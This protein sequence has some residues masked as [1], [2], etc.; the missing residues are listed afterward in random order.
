MGKTAGNIFFSASFTVA[1]F[2]SFCWLISLRAPLFAAFINLKIGAL[3]RSS[4]LH[5]SNIFPFSLFEFILTLSPAIFLLLIYFIKKSKPAKLRTNFFSILG[6]FLILFSVFVFTVVIGYNEN[7]N[8]ENYDVSDEKTVLAAEYLA[9]R[10][11]SFAPHAFPEK[12]QLSHKLYKA[13]R[14]LFPQSSNPQ[15]RIK[16][17]KNAHLASRLGI[18]AQFSFPTS[19]INVNFKAPEYISTFSAAH[20][21][22][23]LFGISDEAQASLYAYR[24]S[25]LTEDRGIMYSAYLSAFEYVFSDVAKID[26]DLSAEIYESLSARAKSDIR[27]Y[28]DFYNDSKGALTGASDSANEVLLETIDKNGSHSYSAFSKLIVLYLSE[29]GFL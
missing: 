3:L 10:I 29:N 5:F 24:A 8:E 17:I 13:Y 25:M 26:P 6:V 20:E 21:F 7:T 1:L 28:R 12:E 9:E 16:A 15:P 19:E 27:S 14:S 23:H 4:L 2:A 22:S 18:L 11:N